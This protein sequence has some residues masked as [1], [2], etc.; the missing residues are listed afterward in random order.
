MSVKESLDGVSKALAGILTQLKEIEDTQKRI[1]TG[2]DTY[3]KAVS[4]VVPGGVGGG[5]NTMAGSM[6]TFSTP[7]A[8]GAAPDAGGGSGGSM[9]AGA[10][11]RVPGPVA[12]VAGALGLGVVAAADLAWNMTPGVD[13]AVDFAAG[14]YQAAKFG[15]SGYDPKFYGRLKADFG[16]YVT[17]PTDLIAGANIA[18]MRGQGIG[19]SYFTHVN[20]QAAAISATTGMGNASA[21]MAS[22]QLYT[23]STSGR[24]ASA[25][26]F[27]N[28]LSTGRPKDIAEVVDQMW[29]RWFGSSNKKVSTEVVSAQLMGGFIGY[30]L[31][32]LFGDSPELYSTIVD[33]IY[34]KAQSGGQLGLYSVSESG[35]RNGRKSVISQSKNLGNTPDNNPQ[36][37]RMELETERTET[38]IATKDSLIAGYQAS[39]EVLKKL[40]DS[41]QFMA[42]AMGPEGDLFR[43]MLTAKG[44]FQS[45]V[46]TSEGGAVGGVLQAL[47]G[48]AAMGGA[49]GLAK[50]AFGGGAAGPGAVG[51]MMGATGP[52]MAKAGG[53][54]SRIATAIPGLGTALFGIESTIR[55]T[56]DVKD[57]WN[58]DADLATKLMWIAGGGQGR[59]GAVDTINNILGMF[60]DVELPF[61]DWIKGY[62]R[63][64]GGPIHGSGTSTSDSIRANLSRGEYVINANA[65]KK[66]GVSN[67]NA[68]NSLGHDF[69]SGFA[70]P[71]KNFSEGGTTL[72]GWPAMQSGDPRL[73]SFS[74]AGSSWIFH[75]DYG[76][77]LVKVLEAYAA[78]PA[79]GQV[80][81]GG[82]HSYRQSYY[83]TGFS[84]HAAGVAFDL[85][86]GYWGMPG[87]TR[88]QTPEQQSAVDQILAANPGIEW[89]GNWTGKWHDPM[90]FEI[91]DP[92]VSPSG[93]GSSAGVGTEPVMPTDAPGDKKEAALGM[94]GAAP[95]SVNI[96]RGSAAANPAAA[97]MG[98]ESGFKQAYSLAGL[99]GS[100]RLVS[101]F[102][103]GA[104]IAG[105][106]AGVRTN[107]AGVGAGAGGFPTT[108]SVAGDPATSTT[109]SSGAGA[110]DT[111]ADAPSGEGPQWLYDFL[112]AKGARGEQLRILWT[113]GMRESGGKPKL[114]AAMS[115]GSYTYPNVPPGF[116]PTTENGFLGGRYDV[117]VWQINSQH[118]AKVKALTGGD[119]TTMTDPNKNFEMMKQLSNNFSSWTPWG[120]TGANGNNL[121]YIDWSSWGSSWGGAGGYGATTE[122]RDAG[123][124]SEFDQYNK[125]GYSQGAYRTHNEI[126]KI[127]EGEMIIPAGAAEDFR[128]LMREAVGGTRGARGNIS[129]TL[130]IDKASDEEAE[131][132]AKK[133]KQLLEDD[134]QLDRLRTR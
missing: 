94:L 52:N 2:A 66:I 127:H 28:S 20:K 49:F 69:G 104:R 101:A 37:S 85:N 53:L 40:N 131:R 80:T 8:G 77:M 36:L 29:A 118:H 58:S 108:N 99:G 3:K 31:N 90:H 45:F 79:L 65:A 102:T 5:A 105:D 84:N 89:G 14:G 122:A 62:S 119:M 1:S 64:S 71:A 33:A 116:D 133:V 18:A 96:L 107:P 113:I 51:K 10:L 13:D 106:L 42:T 130:N 60:G 22:G 117:G 61:G 73:K 87:S 34:K 97:I 39:V 46:G 21:M 124:M 38:L 55:G 129:I 121:S 128:A 59:S 23:G 43:A 115:R 74:A 95:A 81:N 92:S 41:I 54:A 57:V 47:L 125:Q 27:T 103:K 9:M 100:A 120:I 19:S 72:D 4:G 82:S 7:V 88:R 17:S 16:Q 50:R 30:D 70:S 123:F 132:F 12:K 126:A 76:D 63:A 134:N 44:F 68:L 91:T 15:R 26:I 110:I 83:G 56:D 114:I 93:G 67:L 78:S 111:G 48:G 32:N 75:Q 98:G 112:V 35:S 86:V 109:P 25:G 24:L 11:A 6:G